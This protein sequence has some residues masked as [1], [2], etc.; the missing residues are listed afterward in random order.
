MPERS[1]KIGR[2]MVRVSQIEMMAAIEMASSSAP[3]DADVMY[4]MRVVSSSMRCDVRSRTFCSAA[5]T[6]E[7]AR[8]R[9]GTHACDDS[10]SASL[11]SSARAARDS[12]GAAALMRWIEVAM[13]DANVGRL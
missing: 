11:A 6:T 4:A 13:S 3:M 8:L 5:R 2:L 1:S 7:S 12:E 10:E 9:A